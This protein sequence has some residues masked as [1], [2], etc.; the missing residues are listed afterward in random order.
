MSAARTRYRVTP[1]SPNAPVVLV[2]AG[3]PAEAFD[4]AVEHLVKHRL[5]TRGITP[6]VTHNPVT[7]TY[8]IAQPRMTR[9]VYVTVTEESTR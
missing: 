9:P 3:G 5:L 1:L 6:V 2:V 7:S 4:I 8:A